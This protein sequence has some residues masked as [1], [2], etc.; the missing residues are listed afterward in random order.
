MG[1]DTEGNGHGLIKGTLPAIFWRD[2]EKH[3]QLQ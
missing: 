3:V 2:F 1:N